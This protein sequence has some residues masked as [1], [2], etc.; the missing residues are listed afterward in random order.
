M[1]WPLTKP[2]T[3]ASS[4]F[5]DADMVQSGHPC[6]MA[7]ISAKLVTFRVFC[8]SVSKSNPLPVGLF[9]LEVSVLEVKVHALLTV[10]YVS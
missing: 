4:W 6:E 2:A 3:P 8:V 7:T 10:L 5:V 1:F 9:T